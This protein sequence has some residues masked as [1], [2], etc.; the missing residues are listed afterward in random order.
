MDS[1]IIAAARALALR[2]AR[3][4]LS[5]IPLRNDAPA[6]AMRGIAVAQLRDLDRA[7]MLLRR[8]TRALGPREAVA[9]ETVH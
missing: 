1:L 8:A 3:G 7:K 4:Q 5:H 9:R 2:N 6:P